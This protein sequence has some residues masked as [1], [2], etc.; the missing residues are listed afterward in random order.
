MT[1]PHV[2]KFSLAATQVQSRGISSKRFLSTLVSDKR[3]PM[4][5]H[6]AVRERRHKSKVSAIPRKRIKRGPFVA[7]IV[8]DRRSSP[9]VYHCIVQK[10]AGREVLMWTQERSLDEAT[11]VAR[12]HL[13]ELRAQEKRQNL[14]DLVS[15]EN[16]QAA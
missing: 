4:S 10:V 12:R 2:Q 8:S 14:R 16:S 15:D 13:A 5:S 9:R 3:A 6:L 11:E 1:F 7:E